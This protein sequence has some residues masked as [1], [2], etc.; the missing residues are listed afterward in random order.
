[1]LQGL[2]L[3]IAR[4]TCLS[5][6]SKVSSLLSKQ[7]RRMAEG[8]RPSSPE[9]PAGYET[10]FSLMYSPVVGRT[11]ELSHQYVHAMVLMYV[12]LRINRCGTNKG[13]HFLYK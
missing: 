5:F 11:V 13:I 3:E 1:M 2:Q 8:E 7:V 9:P 6:E 4:A 10:G 12:S